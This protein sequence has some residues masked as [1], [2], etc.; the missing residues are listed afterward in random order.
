MSSWLIVVCPKASVSKSE[1][2]MILYIYMYQKKETITKAVAH[3]INTR[4]KAPFGDFWIWCAVGCVSRVMTSCVHKNTNF[5]YILLVSLFFS[6]N[7][8]AIHCCSYK[9]FAR[10]S[11]STLLY[12]STRGCYYLFSFKKKKTIKY[13]KWT[14]TIF[15]FFWINFGHNR[16]N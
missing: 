5:M 9:K 10:A 2:T 12:C 8:C 7:Q 3:Q 16:F 14:L 1:T 6:F 4:N 15:V 13:D 11:Y